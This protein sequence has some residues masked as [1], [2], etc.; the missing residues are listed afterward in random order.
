[1][2]RT[3][4]A[5]WKGD[6]KSGSGQVS[7]QTK[8][9]NATPYG[10]KSRFE[11]GRETNPEELIAAAHASCFAMATSAFLG[12]AGHTPTQI[13][14]TASLTLEQVEGNWTITKIHLDLNAQVP[15]ITEPDFQKI[16]TEAKTNC[17]ISRLLKAE[18][19]LTAKL[20]Q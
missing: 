19:T 3:A 13:N 20:T 8:T 6:L 14:T 11:D 16:A 10:F 12:K 18:I 9:L 7:T 15:G 2:I 17:P 5:V 4:N 1:M